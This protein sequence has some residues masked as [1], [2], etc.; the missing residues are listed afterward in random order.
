HNVGCTL[1]TSRM[2]P[3]KNWT[4]VVPLVGSD[5]EHFRGG[6]G[7]KEDPYVFAVPHCGDIITGIA[8]ESSSPVWNYHFSLVRGDVEMPLDLSYPYSCCHSVYFPLLAVM[9]NDHYINVY[10]HLWGE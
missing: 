7:V 8:L 10:L 2:D 1:K 3:W 9:R 6:K 4:T 5:P